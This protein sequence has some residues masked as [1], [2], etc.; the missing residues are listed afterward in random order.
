[1][2][3]SSKSLLDSVFLW[4]I[5]VQIVNKIRA[6]A[7]QRL[8]KTLVDEIDSQYGKLLLSPLPL[9]LPC[10]FESESVI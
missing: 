4:K 3:P 10:C 8:F 5:V 2:P 6:Q 7:L 9:L 1:M